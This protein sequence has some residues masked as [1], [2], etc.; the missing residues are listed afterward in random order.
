MKADCPDCHGN[1]RHES[2]NPNIRGGELHE[3]CNTCGGSGEVDV[4]PSTLRAAVADVVAAWDNEGPVPEYH[5]RVKG[6]LRGSW[7]VLSIALE[8]LARLVK[9]KKLE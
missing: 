1:G 9:E 5:R 6:Q 7:P 4:P 3:H 8:R 2:T